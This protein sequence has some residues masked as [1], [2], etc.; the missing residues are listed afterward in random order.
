MELGRD[1]SGCTCITY[2]AR[3]KNGPQGDSKSHFLI[4]NVHVYDCGWKRKMITPSTH[5]SP[6]FET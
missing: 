5:L 3:P 1:Q 4:K 6:S 2:F